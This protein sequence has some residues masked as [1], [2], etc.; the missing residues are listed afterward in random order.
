[1]NLILM[2]IPDDPAA[3][4]GWLE[5]RL[6]GP[7]LA[8]LV[9]E[10]SAV[11]GSAGSPGPAGLLDEYREAILARG[12][13]ALPAAAVGQLLRRPAALLD[14][15]ELVLAEGG[16]YWQRLA[17]QSAAFAESADRGR[18]RLEAILDADGPAG[19]AELRRPAVPWYRRPWVVSLATAAAVLLVVYLVRRSSEPLPHEREQVEVKPPPAA[20]PV[21]G[22]EKPGALREDGPAPAYLRRLADAAE[23]WSDKRPDD[24]AALARRIGELRQG[25]SLLIFAE[26]KPLAA[27]DRDWLVRRCRRWAEQLDRQQAALEAGQPVAQV[28]AEAD[29]IVKQIVK[30]LRTRAVSLEDVG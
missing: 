12:L 17:A 26:H 27:V 22:W 28:Q 30:V 23:E 3:L 20:P 5:R 9:A 29:E 4:A 6:V 24:A 15:Q 18:R 10:L 8:A 16:P 11:H 19:V 21:W 1:M 7:D 2:D 25:C 14:L 13:G